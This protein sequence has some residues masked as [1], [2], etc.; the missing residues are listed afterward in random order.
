[1]CDT[2]ADKSAPGGSS[3]EWRDEYPGGHLE[4]VRPAGKQ[5]V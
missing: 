4:A 5:K 2:N 1:M 3:K